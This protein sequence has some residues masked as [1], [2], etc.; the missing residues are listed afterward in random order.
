METVGIVDYGMGNLLSVR[1]AVE[2]CGASVQICQ[3]PGDLSNVTRIVIPG[4]GAFRDCIGQLKKSGLVPALE[5]RVLSDGLPTLG[6]CMGMQVLAGM[7]SEGGQFEGLGWIPGE[8]KRLVPQEA[9]LRIPHIGW[10]NIAFAA[11]NPLFKGIP[12]NADFYFVHSYFFD[13]EKSENIVATADY[14]GKFTAA[15]S[16]K[17]IFGTQFHPEKSQEMGLRLLRNFLN[18]KGDL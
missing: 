2:S 14:G 12:D 4:V 18:W 7:S 10:N 11:N 17:N 6:I 16:R 3:S 8:V 15:V 1:H 9:G 13:C 5:K